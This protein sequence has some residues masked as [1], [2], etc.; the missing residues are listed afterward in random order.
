M[1]PTARQRYVVFEKAEV[2][3]DSR[4]FVRSIDLA[5]AIYRDCLEKSWTEMNREFG[6]KLN[7]QNQVS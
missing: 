4:D 5:V 7:R 2:N 6:Q 1:I 3:K